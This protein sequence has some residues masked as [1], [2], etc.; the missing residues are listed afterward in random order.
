MNSIDNRTLARL[1]AAEGAFARRITGS[2]DELAGT[3]EPDLQARLRFARERAVERMARAKSL[4][5]APAPAVVVVQ[6]GGAAVLGTAGG[7]GSGR[8]WHWVASIVPLVALLGGLLA[9]DHLQSRSQI[10][11][12]TDVDSALLAD[13]LPPQAYSDPGFLEFLRSPEQ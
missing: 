2:L 13:D 11:A 8:W 4:A 5:S 3:L 12:A 10:D 7:P 1:E 9:I 6:H